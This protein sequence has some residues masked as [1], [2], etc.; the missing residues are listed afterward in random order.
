MSQTI[1][2]VRNLKF[3]YGN[4]IVLDNVTI[5]LNENEL[6]SI[7]GP[8]GSGKT[9]LLKVILGILKPKEGSI[10]IIKTD[11]KNFKKWSIV[12]YVPQNF[13]VEN[14]LVTVKEFI[15]ASR[16]NDKNM[17]NLFGIDKFLQ[18]KLC[19][20]SFGQIRRVL[21]YTALARNPKIIIMD[22]PTNGLDEDFKRLFYK[23]LYS[24]KKK[25]C[26]IL[27]VSHDLEYIV[28]IS[29]KIYYL[30]GGK[31]LEVKTHA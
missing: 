24:Y 23:L 22:E 21:I 3:S 7:I 11:I 30:K 31:L 1:L 17:L 18:K 15:T 10:K 6:I 4:R 14:R 20:L 19:E 29:D 12:G 2:E 25:G 13:N 27:L 9:T 8:N 5:T 28:N 26:G 16:I